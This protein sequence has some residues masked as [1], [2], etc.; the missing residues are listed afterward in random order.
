MEGSWRVFSSSLWWLRARA[1][2][3]NRSTVPLGALCSAWIV[4]G[5]SAETAKGRGS[6]FSREIRRTFL[7]SRSLCLFHSSTAALGFSPGPACFPARPAETADANSGAA[8]FCS[9]FSSVLH[10]SRNL[11]SS[12][13][14]LSGSSGTK[15]GRFTGAAG[16]SPPVLVEDDDVSR[17]G[18]GVAEACSSSSPSPLCIVGSYTHVWEVVQG[19]DSRFN[20]R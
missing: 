2:T 16:R 8:S 19:K 7:L 17:S 10:C 5:S 3:K 18:M 11:M 6:V 14:S 12:T 13:G 4:S 1:R 9:R 15:A 20:R